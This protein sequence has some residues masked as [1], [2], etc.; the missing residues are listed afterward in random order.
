MAIAES[1]AAQLELETTQQNKLNALRK[2]ATAN[3]IAENKAR[4]DAALEAQQIEL[5]M[6]KALNQG[7]QDGFR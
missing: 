7:R 5:E 6:F 1:N 2:E 4:L 3:A